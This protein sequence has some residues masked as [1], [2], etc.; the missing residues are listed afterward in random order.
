MD[1][2][3][4]S[5]AATKALNNIKQIFPIMIGI[6]I[7]LSIINILVPKDFYERIFTSNLI[8]DPFIGVTLGSISAGTPIT[9]YIIGG[10]LL[11]QGIS[12]I[13]VTAFILGWVTVGIIQLPIE[14]STLGKRFAITRNIVSFLSAII[15]AI[16]IFFTL[17]IF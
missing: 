4:I 10:E 8:L 5:Q 12:I 7:L 15:I 13:A 9:S 17:K 16:L 6:L 2:K 11:K 3:T 14:I 1:K